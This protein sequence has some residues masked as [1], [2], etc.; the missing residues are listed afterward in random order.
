MSAITLS[1]THMNRVTVLHAG[2][3]GNI[4]A[5]K[6]SS[7]FGVTNLARTSAHTMSLFIT[8]DENL[9]SFST[10]ITIPPSCSGGIAGRSMGLYE[11]QYFHH[12]IFGKWRVASPRTRCRGR[13]AL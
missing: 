8:S 5:N 11:T 7:R 9:S 10:Y 4:Y 6:F 12:N 13:T 2:L 3:L 1:V